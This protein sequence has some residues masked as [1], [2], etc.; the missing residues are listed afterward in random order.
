MHHPGSASANRDTSSPTVTDMC[1]GWSLWKARTHRIAFLPA[2]ENGHPG[3]VSAMGRYWMPLG[4]A[5]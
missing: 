1:V 3:W 5:A 2:P 4:K